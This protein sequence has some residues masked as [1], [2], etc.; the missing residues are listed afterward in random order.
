VFVD[1]VMTGVVEGWFEALCIQ[2]LNSMP[3]WPVAVQTMVWSIIAS[4][5]VM[6]KLSSNTPDW[7]IKELMSQLAVKKRIGWDF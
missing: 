4:L 1:L 5:Y 2:M 6:Q 3:R 7:L